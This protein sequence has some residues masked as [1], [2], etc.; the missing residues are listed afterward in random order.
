MGRK[1]GKGFLFLAGIMSGSACRMIPPAP[2]VPVQGTL[3]DLRVLSGE[4]SGR[5]W[6]KA[7]GRHGILRFSLPEHATTG[8]GEVEIT[9]SPSLRLL[10]GAPATDELLPK[11]T[12]V[13]DI[14][15]VRVEGS[16]VWG[17]MAPYWDPDCD[18]RARTVF[19]GEIVGNRITGTFSTQ[20]ASADRRILTGQ[21]LAIRAG[22]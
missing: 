14:K 17:T 21:W 12:T 15:L 5:Y 2:P 9:F 6:S 3:D 4:W 7:T 22:G 8:S 13:I 18:C 16:R 19:E 1:S 20:R 10:Q 11:T